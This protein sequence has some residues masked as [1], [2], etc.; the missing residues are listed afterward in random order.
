MPLKYYYIVLIGCTPGVYSTLEECYKQVNNITLYYKKFLTIKEANKKY[1]K[2]QLKVKRKKEKL[3][4]KNKIVIYTDG[5]YKDNQKESYARI[6]V[7]HKDGSK[8]IAEPLTGNLQTNNYTE[9]Y[10]IIKVL[11]TC[12][13][14]IKVIEIKTNS[15]FVVNSIE[16]WIYK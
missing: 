2:Y 14:P 8:E 10:A 4:S 7:Y 1:E 16:T 15:C 13:D 9:L 5:S 6:G 12:E 11:E 3:N